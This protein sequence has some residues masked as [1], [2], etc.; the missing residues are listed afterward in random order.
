MYVY[1]SMYNKK[2]AY[3][4]WLQTIYLWFCGHILELNCAGHSSHTSFTWYYLIKEK[5]VIS[6][7]K[8]EALKQGTKSLV[9]EFIAWNL[10]SLFAWVFSL[11]RD[12]EKCIRQSQ[13]INSFQSRVSGKFRVY[14]KEHRHINFLSRPQFLLLKAK[15]LNFVEVISC[16][17]GRHII[18]WHSC[19]KNIV[20][21]NHVRSHPILQ[22]LFQKNERKTTAKSAA[23]EAKWEKV[24]LIKTRC[25]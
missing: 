11:L 22:R 6:S 24:C 21:S 5:H 15:A 10:L 4:K 8:A 9:I 14:I 13:V 1:L 23:Q 7:R 17:L 20:C 25:K 2:S 18:C 16:L 12:L 3:C 19:R